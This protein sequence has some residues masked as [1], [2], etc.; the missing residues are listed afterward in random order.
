[1]TQLTIFFDG[2]CP[3]CAAEMDHLVRLNTEAKLAFEN[4]YA[5][6]FSQRFPQIDLEAA[7]LVLHG[8]LQSGEM[9]YGLEVT[10]QAWALV[11]KRRWVAILRWPLFKQCAEI[12]YR[13]FAKHR[14]RISRLLM[15]KARCERCA[16]AGRPE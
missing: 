7:D 2:G 9:I 16:L 3:L 6:D 12:G 8:Q 4:I 1:M 14:H 5:R 10:Y 15:G 11:G 13:F